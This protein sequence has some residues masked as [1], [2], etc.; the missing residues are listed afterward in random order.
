MRSCSEPDTDPILLVLHGS[1]RHDQMN[2]N[3]W[4]DVTMSGD[5]IIRLGGDLTR[6][7]I[8]EWGES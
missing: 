5:E 8:E 1:N 2:L 4:N 7:H 6:S 3:V